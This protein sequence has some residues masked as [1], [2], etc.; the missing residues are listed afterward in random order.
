MLYPEK[1]N[2]LLPRKDTIYKMKWWLVDLI[3][4]FIIVSFMLCIILLAMFFYS[5]RVDKLKAIKNRDNTVVEEK[6][7]KVMKFHGVWP[8][9]PFPE[10]N[11]ETGKCVFE[12]NGKKVRM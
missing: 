1:T 10:C 6:D 7:V 4:S 9:G 2:R 8:H 11:E 12:R 5:E 3:I